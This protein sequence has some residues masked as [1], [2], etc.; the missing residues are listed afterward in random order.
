MVWESLLN[1]SLGVVP[2]NITNIFEIVYDWVMIERIF[3]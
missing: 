3:R 1:N 2:T